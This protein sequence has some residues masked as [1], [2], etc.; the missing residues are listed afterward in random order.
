VLGKFIAE[1]DV[2]KFEP[3]LNTIK[4]IIRNLHKLYKKNPDWFEVP[5]FA[6]KIY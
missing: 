3:N 2:R 5:E 6:I 4:P 1:E